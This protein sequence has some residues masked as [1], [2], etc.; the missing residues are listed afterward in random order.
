M[1]NLGLHSE[2][3]VLFNDNVQRFSSWDIQSIVVEYY[4]WSDVSLS[5][6]VPVDETEVIPGHHTVLD[7]RFVLPREVITYRNKV[8]DSRDT[9]LRR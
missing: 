6:G 7:E 3:N 1:S 4:L 8:L 9:T 5:H 2:D